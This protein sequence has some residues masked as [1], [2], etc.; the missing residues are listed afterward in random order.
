GKKE[1]LAELGKVLKSR[2]GTG[3]SVKEGEILIQGDVAG[4]VLDILNQLGYR[5]K[6]AGG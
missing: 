6:K 5:A 3:G 1:D 2:C 4:R